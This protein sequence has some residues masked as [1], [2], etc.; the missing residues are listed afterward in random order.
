MS[1]LL[2]YRARHGLYS[3]DGMHCIRFVNSNHIFHLFSNVCIS[4]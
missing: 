4:I 2:D 1:I 3:M